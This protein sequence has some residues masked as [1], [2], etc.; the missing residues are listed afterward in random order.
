MAA[1]YGRDMF[2]FLRNWQ[3]LFQSE[4]MIFHSHQHSMN[5]RCTTPSSTL[6]VSNL[7]LSF[8]YYNRCVMVS[9]CGFNLHFPDGKLCWL[10]FYVTNFPLICSLVMCLCKSFVHLLIELFSYYWVFESFL[11]IL[12]N[13]SF[14]YMI[15]KYF[16]LVCGLSFHSF[17]VVF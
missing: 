3:T 14:R 12:K 6:D 5:S 2:T 1:S 11:Y 4:R 16:L 13:V 10:C 15:C 17:N 7:F 8:N 9:Q